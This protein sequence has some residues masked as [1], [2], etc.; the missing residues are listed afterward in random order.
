MMPK[1]PVGEQN[2]EER[3]YR[4]WGWG[5]DLESPCVVGQVVLCPRIRG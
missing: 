2:E 4:D 5:R 3:E 1:F